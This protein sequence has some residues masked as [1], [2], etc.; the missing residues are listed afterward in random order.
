MFESFA[1]TI[2]LR[3]WTQRTV[4]FNDRATAMKP[5]TIGWIDLT[6][7]DAE[8][9]RDFYQEVVGWKS[10]PVDMGDYNDYSMV[11][12]EGDA[13]AGICHARGGN[14]AMPSTWTIYI[15]VE[16]HQESFPSIAFI[17]GCFVTSQDG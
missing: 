10:D 15:I 2:P 14:A 4:F 17:I 8:G 13:V 6:V 16:N 7:D 9:V 3:D 11:P 12:T 5:G 1:P